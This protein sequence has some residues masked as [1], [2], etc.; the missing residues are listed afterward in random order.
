MFVHFTF[1]FAFIISVCNGQRRVAMSDIT[2]LTFTKGMMTTGRRAAPINQLSCRGS[3]CYKFE[4]DVVQC[5]VVGHDGSGSP[6]WTCRGTFPDG[7]DLGRTDVVCEGYEHAN[8]PFILEGS[9]GLEYTLIDR[10]YNNYHSDSFN[11]EG[12]ASIFAYIIMIFVLLVVV[13]TCISIIP[14]PGI[15]NDYIPRTTY[16]PR[17]TYIPRDTYVHS[18]TYIPTASYVTCESRRSRGSSSSSS[19]S[20]HTSTG[21]GT[22][23]SR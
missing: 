16:I 12:V 22:T 15:H 20:T 18:T 5:T 6:Q 4:P 10:G 9:C 2:A 8:D 23:R 1:F 7:L 17:A 14:P 13:Y 21:F 3:S 19:S 11:Y